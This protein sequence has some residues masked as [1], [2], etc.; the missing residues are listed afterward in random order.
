[1][2]LVLGL[3][4]RP[5][6]LEQLS[7]L[8]APCSLQVVVPL[9]HRLEPALKLDPLVHEQ[10]ALLAHELVP[11]FLGQLVH[12]RLHL[13][14]LAALLLGHLE[15][16]ALFRHLLGQLAALRSLLLLSLPLVTLR[17]APRG[18]GMQP[19]LLLRLL[20][21]LLERPHPHL[22]LAL[23]L[24]HPLR[25][26]FAP[27]NHD[28]PAENGLVLLLGRGSDG[29]LGRVQP[30]AHRVERDGEVGQR[31]AHLGRGGRVNLVGRLVEPAVLVVDAQRQELLLGGPHDERLEFRPTQKRDGR[32]R[33]G[34][35][36]GQV[37][38]L[39]LLKHA[40]S[41]QPAQRR[42]V[43]R[44]RR[45]RLDAGE[46]GGDGDGEVE[47]DVGALDQ[48]VQLA[49][50]WRRLG[51]HP[52][53][54]GFV[55]QDRAR[56]GRGKAEHLG[57]ALGLLVFQVILEQV[58]VEHG[59]GGGDGQGGQQCARCEQ[60]LR[61]GRQRR[62]K[63]ERCVEGAGHGVGVEELVVGHPKYLS[64][65]LVVGS[66]RDGLGRLL[67]ELEQGV[68]VLDRPVRLLPQLHLD[69]RR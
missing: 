24:L 7:L 22:L 28:P 8:L 40:Q 69:G 60:L 61:L 31:L 54:V 9:G 33:L 49:D 2:P 5:P 11:V 18:V 45:H 12:V 25:L 51:Q 56:G 48:C 39:H 58:K 42:L 57:H 67:H 53:P 26:L 38:P 30:F 3:L 13:A 66:D 63:A 55:K 50:H 47:R 68:H 36:D 41:H 29:G 59:R 6:Q 52:R 27:L 21:G 65:V 10:L 32:R 43:L 20:L 34:N 17:V 1:M 16:L 19:R 4:R 62:L 64:Q 23:L 37:Q 44:Q 15:R 35:R 14:P 46:D